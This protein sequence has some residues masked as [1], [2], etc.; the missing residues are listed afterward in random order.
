MTV[1]KEDSNRECEQKSV[2]SVLPTA[3]SIK[4]ACDGL[5]GSNDLLTRSPDN[6]LYHTMMNEFEESLNMGQKL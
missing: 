2:N 3:E 4:L 5:V 1:F 6:A